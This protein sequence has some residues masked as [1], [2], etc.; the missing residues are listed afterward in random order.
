MFY[1]LSKLSI[2]LHSL[3]AKLNCFERTK[4]AAVLEKKTDEEQVGL[5][6]SLTCL[7]GG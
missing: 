3:K 1:S 4:T 2:L 7:E 5:I 6:R